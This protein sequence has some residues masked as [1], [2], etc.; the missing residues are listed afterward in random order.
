[1]FECTPPEKTKEATESY[2]VN[3]MNWKLNGKSSQRRKEQCVSTHRGQTAGMESPNCPE[4]PRVQEKREQL[5]QPRGFMY[6]YI[7]NG[8]HLRLDGSDYGESFIDSD[9]QLSCPDAQK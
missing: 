4:H 8:A 1:M 6:C 7:S 3:L 9:A 2:S 5:S